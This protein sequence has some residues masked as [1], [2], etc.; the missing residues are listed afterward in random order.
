MFV[1]EQETFMFKANNKNVN[2]PTQFCVENIS[3]RFGATGSIELCLK[4]SVW[5]FFRLIT[6]LLISLT[7]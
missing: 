4:G 6:V 7:C 1:N 5:N 2:F 3:Y